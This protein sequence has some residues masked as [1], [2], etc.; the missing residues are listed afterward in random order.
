VQSIAEKNHKQVVLGIDPEGRAGE[1]AVA[2]GG[3]RQLAAAEAEVS[4]CEHL[5]NSV[6]VTEFSRSESGL[7]EL[8][9]AQGAC[10]SFIGLA[11]AAGGKDNVTLVLVGPG[12][13]E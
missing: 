5:D 9:D 10:E 1:A 11:L 4:V 12:S 2:E 13:E 8:P 6:A 3:R 7:D